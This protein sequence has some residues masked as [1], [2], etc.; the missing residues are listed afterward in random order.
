MWSAVRPGKREISLDQ[1]GAKSNRRDRHITVRHCRAIESFADTESC[2]FLLPNAFACPGNI[3]GF[4]G[5]IILGEQPWRTSP[6][7][8]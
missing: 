4:T 3:Y 7:G 2:I 8:R 5:K 1:G 6:D